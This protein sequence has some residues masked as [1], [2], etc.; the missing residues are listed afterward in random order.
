MFHN[1]SII[2]RWTIIPCIRVTKSNI[3]NRQKYFSRL[4]QSIRRNNK[5]QRK[6]ELLDSLAVNC[7]ASSP[8]I[9]NTFLT[10]KTIARRYVRNLNY[11]GPQNT[12]RERSQSLFRLIAILFATTPCI[13]SKIR[14]PPS[15][16]AVFRRPNSLKGKRN[17]Q[18]R[19]T[20]ANLFSP[21][22]KLISILSCNSSR[23]G[24][25]P[26][27]VSQSEEGGQN[28]SFAFIQPWTTLLSVS[29]L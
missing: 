3:E 10:P 27:G 1:I 14:P 12:K 4:Q 9:F 5:F 26:P 25:P 13:P 8:S 2:L 24:D 15:P 20:G 19:R 29:P 7:L 28:A 21:R 11:T 6:S 16:A 17:D 22:D 23:G 18:F